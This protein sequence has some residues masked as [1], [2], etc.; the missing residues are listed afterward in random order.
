[1][2]RDRATLTT[3]F[4]NYRAIA[5]HPYLPHPCPSIPTRKHHFTMASVLR[6]FVSTISSPDFRLR[7][8]K[9]DLCAFVNTG[10]SGEAWGNG[11][12]GCRRRS[13]FERNAA[14][15]SEKAEEPEQSLILGSI[16]EPSLTLLFPAF[17][18]NCPSS[19]VDTTLVLPSGSI[20]SY[21]ERPSTS[22]RF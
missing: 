13:L 4:D 2:V 15:L 20:R 16:A 3:A 21:S 12:A 18:L 11:S 8:R 5:A 10:R 7:E 1:M 22:S 6:T 17:L 14:A 9:Q 19:A